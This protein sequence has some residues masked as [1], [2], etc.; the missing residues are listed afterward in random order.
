MSYKLQLLPI[1]DLKDISVP[2][3]LKL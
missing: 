1:L 2:S 3:W